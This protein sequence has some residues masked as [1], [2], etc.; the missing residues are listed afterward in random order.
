MTFTEVVTGVDYNDFT[1]STAITSAYVYGV[2]DTGDTR[3]V[4]VY[5]GTGNGTIQL[6]LR[7]SGT[8]IQDLAGN[9][10][11]G[12]FYNGEI[13]TVRKQL[14]LRSV[15]TYDGWLLEKTETNNIDGTLN[16]TATTLRLGDDAA[17]KHVQADAVHGLVLQDIPNPFDAGH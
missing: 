9:P 4:T 17:R 7:S 5:T 13:Y 6:N 16:N 10:I 2:G 8:D 11:N 14:T 1:L 15:R 3:T 12:G